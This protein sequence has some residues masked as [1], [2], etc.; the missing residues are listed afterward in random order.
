MRRRV[1]AA[2]SRSPRAEVVVGLD[3]GPSAREALRWAA[4]H[5]WR[6]GLVLRAV[7]AISWPYGAL[8]VG[9]ETLLVV[10]LPPAAAERAYRHGITRLFDEVDRRPDWLLQFARGDAGPVL[11]EQSRHS[12]LLVIGC[13]GHV[14]LG[15]LVA[16]SVAH[17]CLTHASCPVAAVPPRAARPDE[18]AASDAAAAGRAVPAAAPT[19][20]PSSRRC[21]RAAPAPDHPAR[22]AAT[23]GAVDLR[24]M[25]DGLLCWHHHQRA[26]AG[27]Q[28]APDD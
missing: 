24:L 20:A 9:G 27:L 26:G 8:T 4:D 12:E 10:D 3:S 23:G 17:H 6:R 11:V 19:P 7:H 21:G 15:R 28:D 22:S 18:T 13:P 14:G 1:P 25:I 2:A 5:A 16:G